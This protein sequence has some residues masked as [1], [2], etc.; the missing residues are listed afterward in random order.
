MNP[1]A[2]I[3]QIQAWMKQERLTVKVQQ[4]PRA[5]AHFLIKYPA[6]NQGHMFAVVVPKG[7]DLVA[8]SSMTRV[9]K[10]QQKEMAKHMEEDREEW[11]E[12]VHEARL[13]LI[14]STVDWGIHMGHTGKEKAGPLQAFN[15]SLPIWFDGLTKNQFM[16]TLRNLWLAK[17]GVIHEIKYSYGPGI[18]ESG[19]VDD[20]P[21]PKTNVESKNTPSGPASASST[22]HE[23]EFDE[24]MTF[25]SGFDPSEWA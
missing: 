3:Q 14:R 25:G 21:K 19:P 22:E 18:G 13:Q 5:E 7:R 24:K 6:G 1:T 16:H 12:W 9:D 4:D 15:V 23:I 8:I 20:W 10:G 2:V 11:L 17:L